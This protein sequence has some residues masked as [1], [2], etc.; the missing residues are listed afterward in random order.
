MRNTLQYPVTK[1]EIIAAI[2]SAIDYELS[3]GLIGGITPL[4]LTKA[5]EFIMENGPEEFYEDFDPRSKK[6]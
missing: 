1:E 4:A 6:Q 3:K 2:N 5:K